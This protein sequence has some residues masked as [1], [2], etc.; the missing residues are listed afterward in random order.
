M[1]YLAHSVA[2]GALLAALAC[3]D[4][5]PQAPI[6]PVGSAG[7][8]AGAG[9]G[10]E[11]GAASLAEAGAENDDLPAAAPPPVRTREEYCAA[12]AELSEGWCDYIDHCCT[13][14]DRGDLNF[15]PGA[16]RDGHEDPT[17][18]LETVEELEMRGAKFDGTAVDACIA[19]LALLYPPAPDSCTGL[20]ARRSLIA[21]RGLHGFSQLASCRK[22]LTG[23]KTQG[24]P[25]DYQSECSP[26]MICAPPGLDVAQPYVCVPQGNEGTPCISDSECRA[27]LF[28]VGLGIDAG[29]RRCGKPLPVGEKCL[30]DDEC[31]AGLTCSALGRCAIVVGLGATCDETHA[32]DLGYQCNLD[33][34]VCVAIPHVGESCTS[35]CDGR[36]ENAKC[37]K[38]C[39]GTLL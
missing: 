13:E 11:G 9:A 20:Q 29:T 36:C 39:G 5:K 38:T 28:C 24:Q 15:A 35:L 30:Y 3:S 22:V 7:A 12:E 2:L 27:D 14:A 37:V 23:V 19:D 26:G 8:G 18:C 6:P 21:V 33:T 34:D 16:C 10:A 31:R 4:D 32:C 1:K 25:C 17:D